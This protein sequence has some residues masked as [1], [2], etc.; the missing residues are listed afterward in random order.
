MTIAYGIAVS[1]VFN[2]GNTSEPV[3]SSWFVVG[4]IYFLVYHWNGFLRGRIYLWSAGTYTRKEEPIQFRLWISV[5]SLF[6]I[7]MIIIGFNKIFGAL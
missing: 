3:I 4:A 5:N 1:S 7:L 6:G 2:D